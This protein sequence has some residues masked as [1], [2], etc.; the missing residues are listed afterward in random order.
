[1]KENNLVKRRTILFGIGALIMGILVLWNGADFVRSAIGLVALYFGFTSLAELFGRLILRN[2]DL[3][4]TSNIVKFLVA[5]LIF[6][7]NYYTEMPVNL[8]I[9]LLGIYQLF[10]GAVYAITYWMFRQ[11]QLEG[12]GR[13]LWDAFW[14][15]GIGLGSILSP[16]GLD[17]EFMFVILGIYLITLGVSNIRDGLFF[18]N[19]RDRKHLRRKARVSLP[20]VFA[21]FIPASNLNKLNQLIQGGEPPLM[22]APEHE[23]KAEGKHRDLEVFIHTSDKDLFGAI[24]H[25]DICYKGQVISFGSYDPFSETL[26]G[27]MGDGVLFKVDRDKY[28]NFLKQGTSKTLFGYTLA[29]TDE[30][31]KAIEERLAE[32]DSLTVEWEPSAELNKGEHIY[33]YVLKHELGAKTYKF[34]GSRFKTYFVLSTNC[35]LLADSIL[36]Q[37]GTD[38]VSPRGVIAP[39]TYQSYLQYE[40]E[41]GN[42][43]VVEQH[44]Y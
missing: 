27:T 32:I 39:G 17:G 1:M 18:D 2:K 33:P 19:D 28:L 20:V 31:E 35:V 15:I 41:S 9:V 21:A 22:P 42:G 7:F 37:A 5:G 3:P 16:G 25:V 23:K 40:Y 29:L 38:I 6:D 10:M 13:F 30:Q 26:F 36:G 11:N 8:I 12:R 44:T 24:G 43:L 14:S 34:T 4:I